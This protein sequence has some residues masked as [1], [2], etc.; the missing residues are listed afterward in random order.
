MSLQSEVE[1]LIGVVP[2]TSEL[3]KALVAG[4]L[5]TVRRVSLSSPDDLW[6][7]TTTSTVP[8]SGLDVESG[9]IQDV[10]YGSKPCKLLPLDKRFQA[11]DSDSIW[12]ATGEYPV[13]YLLDGKIHV[14]PS[15]GID[16]EF[17]IDSSY[18]TGVS[19][20]IV[21]ADDGNSTLINLDTTS[22]ANGDGIHDLNVG[23]FV[24]IFQSEVGANTYYEGIFMVIQDAQTSFTIP[25]VYQEVVEGDFGNYIITKVS[26]SATYLATP[27]INGEDIDNFPETYYRFPV[28][29]AAMSVAMTKMA[30]IQAGIPQLEL[31]EFIVPPIIESPV[32]ELPTYTPPSGLILPPPPESVT[33][34]YSGVGNAPEYNAVAD[35]VLPE[36]SFDIST[37]DIDELVVSP[38]PPSPVAEDGSDGMIDFDTM[39][40]SKIPTYTKPVFN[41]PE[42]PNIPQL[43]LPSLPAPPAYDNLTDVNLTV[44]STAGEQPEVVLPVLSAPDYAAIDDWINVEED[45]ELAGAFLQKAQLMIS[46]YQ[47]KLS[48]EQV[49]FNR[50]MEVYKSKIQE[51]LQEVQQKLSKENQQI[52]ADM[53]VY[54]AK[55]QAYQID[56]NSKVTIWSKNHIELAYAK[57]ISEYEKKIAQYQADMG[58]ETN[59]FNAAVQEYQAEI[60]KVTGEASNTLTA[61]QNRF[62]RKLQKHQTEVETWKNVVN[63]EV[64]NWQT[65]VAQPVMTKFAQIRGENIAEWTTKTSS[66]I[67]HWGNRL[68]SEQQAYNAELQKWQAL[69]A[70]ETTTYS[71]ETGLDLSH[72]Q[73][74]VQAAIQE[75]QSNS[76]FAMEQHKVQLE[77]YQA[78]FNR[79]S[80]INN[81]RNALYQA[82]LGNYNAKVQANIGEFNAIVQADGL[83]Y[84]WLSDKYMLL[85]TQYNE[86]FLT[87]PQK[88]GTR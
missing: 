58:N 25:R 9:K 71:A 10:S 41:A 3:E 69:I 50:D 17:D 8:I 37:I 85:K 14:L 7:F 44:A 6:L 43:E 84:K 22:G 13:Y 29:Y 83:E 60:A 51:E 33:I 21:S 62:A 1:S 38:P 63:N 20:G 52:Q 78:E 74:K 23:D 87:P 30:D 59:S 26:A 75:F 45:T 42:F 77:K 16:D 81:E 68:T 70:K 47:A 56:V 55:V 18:T 82:D 76:N 40:R 79:T 27:V 80:A 32:E 46:E 24:K 11:A 36:L 86:G 49:S 54:N 67:Q 12:F 34:D 5:D 31:P 35:A 57:W 19:N 64:L 48:A 73:A 53:S 72:Y 4:A 2:S 61:D 15:V 65:T 88:E 39:V 28:M 66:E